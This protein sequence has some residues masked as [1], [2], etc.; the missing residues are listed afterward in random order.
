MS[1]VNLN[2]VYV[3]KTGDTIAGN[4]SVGGALTINDGKGTG[5]TYN[6]ANEIT[7]LRN[8]V[9]Q[10]SVSQMIIGQVFN[11]TAIIRNGANDIIDTITPSQWRTNQLFA[12]CIP[13]SNGVYVAQLFGTLLSYTAATEPIYQVAISI[14][15][16]KLPSRE[17]EVSTFVKPEN[18]GFKGQYTGV[19]SNT[20]LQ[21]GVFGTG[22]DRD[23]SAVTDTVLDSSS[24]ATLL[25]NQQ[26]QT[27]STSKLLLILSH[28]N[29][30]Y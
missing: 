26:L 16:V 30:H 15:A 20:G 28:T 11:P 6:V 13:E 2:D 1:W 7:T 12:V 25:N 9:S 19:T 29:Y 17:A 27:R 23:I 10:N 3:N 4:L 22:T 8:S 24:T 14:P 21:F 18:L 5:T